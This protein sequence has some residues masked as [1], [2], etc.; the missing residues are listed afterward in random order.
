MNPMS[1]LILALPHEATDDAPLDYLLLAGSEVV[2]AGRA[3]LA[4]LPR[5]R[6]REHEVVALAPPR[7]LSWHP[8]Q[9]PA[10]IAAGSPR[11]RAVLEGLLEEQLLD[12]PASLHLT[13]AGLP[14]PQAAPGSAWAVACDRRWL[15][16]A[17][18]GLEAAGL[19]PRRVLPEWS[20]QEQPQAHLTQ[21]DG[22]LQ[23]V[24]C[25][26]A[27]VSL[28]PAEAQAQG[29]AWPTG[30]AHDWSAEPE[31]LPAAQALGA[32]ARP[33][34]RHERW[35]AAAQAR[36]DLAHGLLMRRKAQRSPLEWLRAPRWRAARWATL[37]LLATQVVGLNALAWGQ[38]M[39]LAAQREQ[40][41]QVLLRSFPD[42]P[43]SEDD[44]PVQMQRQLE[45]LR[46]AS[47]R[48]QASDL[49]ALLGAVLPALPAGSST[50]ALD[51]AAGQLRL[52]GLALS[53][54]QAQALSGQLQARGY[55]LRAQGPDWVVR[56]LP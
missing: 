10:G 42:A 45:R 36:W 11:L 39:Q 13:V 41:R 27:G 48:P 28:L 19:K 24:A 1:L 6:D 16:M 17:V 12:A 7:A 55:S 18:Q 8:V 31:L 51:Y 33:W 14:G 20:P 21:E 34:P 40:M 4:D 56:A 54:A 3:P 43:A 5:V 44:A 49:V 47:A 52:S 15:A 30:A 35:V 22:R 25:G 53:A 2:D 9:L 50:P 23:L 32:A 38:Q 26:P 46:E 37:G 29:W